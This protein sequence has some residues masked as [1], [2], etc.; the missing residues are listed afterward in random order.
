MREPERH[1]NLVFQ[2]GG[3]RGIAYAGALSTMPSYCK[4]NA[5]AG[6]SAGSIVAALLAIG[7]RDELKE[8]MEQR[9]LYDLLDSADM[10]RAHQLARVWSRALFLFSQSNKRFGRIR[11]GVFML[12]HWGILNKHFSNAWQSKGIHKSTKIRSWLDKVLE[13]KGFDQLA[14]GIEDL[15]IVAA[16]ISQRKYVVYDKTYGSKSIAEAVHASI[17]I[18][19]FFLPFTSGPMHLVDGGILSNYPSYLFKNGAYPTVGLRLMD[20]QPPSRIESTWDYCKGLILTMAEA[21]DKERG[22]PPRCKTFLINTPEDIPSTKFKLSTVDVNRLYHAGTEVKVDWYQ[23]SSPIK[24]MSSYDSDPDKVLDVTL[25]NASKLWEQYRS[26]ASWV[27]E[28]KT[29][30]LMTVRI[31][32]DWSTRYDRTVTHQISG[33]MPLFFSR[34]AL[35][36]PALVK[37]KSFMD[38]EHIFEEITEGSGTKELVKIPALNKDNKKGFLV[39]HVPPVTEGKARTFHYAFS[40]DQEFAETVGKGGEDEVSYSCIKMAF[41]QSLS[42]KINILSDISLPELKF[43]G[44]F[45]Y[46]STV[47]AVHHDEN[48]QKTYRSTTFVLKECAVTAQQNYVITI[49]KKSP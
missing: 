16:D 17:S 10:E 27:K 42:I 47:D 34:V 44:D 40:I 29:V 14:D 1:L 49:K 4:I 9:E 37:T 8:I 38:L 19:I 41:Q 18:P 39:F 48:L 15:K 3:V 30:A 25:Q 13:G 12:R 11:L 26:E 5:V 46:T 32:D 20:L 2:G 35:T 36:A 7:K 43:N 28:L 24:L 23:N 21:H 31:E 45:E 6:T 22:T 33:P